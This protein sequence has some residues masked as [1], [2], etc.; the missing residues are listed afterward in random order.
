MRATEGKGG[1]T[2]SSRTELR[3]RLRSSGAASAGPYGY[4]LAIWGSTTLCARELGSPGLLQ[5]L[6]FIAGAVAAFFVVEAVAYGGL[7]P[8]P[9]QPAKETMAIWGS[10]HLPAAGGAVGLVWLVDQYLD[11]GV[12]WL[13]AGAL[14]TAAYLLLNALQ[15]LLASRLA[16]A[17]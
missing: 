7:R 10:A 15:N 17:P 5:V 1:Q 13:L 8:Q 12:T 9:A 3:A 6:L 16:D 4:T 11:L 2:H 14:A